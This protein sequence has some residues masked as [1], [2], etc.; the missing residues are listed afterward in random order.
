M[1]RK[2]LLL[3][4]VLALAG[5]AGTTMADTSSAE[6][7]LLMHQPAL[8][9]E[10]LA[11]VYG[12]DIW[13][14]KRDGSYPRKLTSHPAE[15][16][17]PQ[18]SPDGRWI[19]FSANYDNNTDVYVISTEGGTAKRLTWHPYSD[20]VNGWSVDGKRVLFASKREIENSRSNQLYEVAVDGG[21]PEKVMQ[22]VATEGSWSSDGKRL[23]Y[24]PYW[25]AFSGSSGW[26]LHRGGATPPIW[27]IDADGKNL[28]K[29]P[30]PNAS[31]TNPIW[32]GEDVFFLS[33]RDNKAVN[34]FRY[35]TATKQVEQ[36][37]HESVWD[38]KSANAYGDQIVYEV[39]G[40]LKTLNAKT[41][42]VSDLTLH[43]QPD[44][45]QLLPGW[46]NASNNLQAMA[47][48]PTG[49]RA[50]VTARG[51]VFTVPLDKGSTRNIT[52]T[53]GER[54]MNALWSPKGG[55]IA[56]VSDRGQKHALVIT[57]QDGANPKRFPLGDA[58]YTLLAWGAK[59]E[60]LIYQD[61]HL[62]LF[63]L[64]IK[65][66]KSTRIDTQSR[67]NDYNISISPDGRWMAYTFAG[68]NYFEHVVLYDFTSGEKFI[69]TDDMA[70]S[71]F[72]AF[73][74]DGKY[75]Y[76]VSSTNAGPLQNGLD[77]TTQEKPVRSGIYVAVLSADGVSPTLPEA[78]DETPVPDKKKK[79]DKKDKN[80]DEEVVTRVDLQGLRERIVA[81][82]VAEKFYTTLDVGEDGALYY[83]DHPQPG[84]SIEPPNSDHIGAT[85]LRYNFT[86]KEVQ[87][88][89]ENVDGFVLSKEGKHILVRSNHTMLSSA[90]VGE[91]LELEPLDLSNVKAWID[92]REEWR[93]IFE[94][95]WKMEKDY[96]YAENM[97]NIDWEAVRTRYTALL[98]HVITRE[99]LNRV[100]VNMIA[101]LQVGHNRVGGGDVHRESSVSVGLLGA[102]LRVENGHYRITK[103]FTGE[104]WNP[105]LKAPLSMP[106]IKVKE[107][108]YILAIN[109]RT[110]NP[111]A[112]I[113]AQ[114]V[115]TAG[116]QVTL[117]VN[118]SPQQKGAHDV[119]VTPI[120]NEVALRQWAWIEENRREVEAKTNGRVGYVY[121]PDTADGGYAYFNR[122]FFAQ[123]NK[124]ALIIDERKNNGGQAANYITDV[125]NRRYLASWKDRD[126]MLW[127]TP[128][129]GMYGPKVMLIDQ[130]AGSGGDFL[131]YS[132]KYMELGPT[133]GKRTW[134]G[135][136]GIS[137]NPGLIDGGYLVVPFFRFFTPE[138]KWA[139]E[140]EG[141]APDID[142]DLDP[143]AVNQGEDTQLQRAID[144]ALERLKTYTPIKQKRAPALPTKLGG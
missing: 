119:V 37:T 14:A 46:K 43:L 7:T 134:G 64:D 72:P 34:L 21:L 129:A 123:I 105:H 79:K 12:G 121:L 38:I 93:Q 9:A 99:D 4:C 100:L 144:E 102:N 80:K 120:S 61:N 11:F 97:H 135:L 25:A 71:S 118:S 28:E 130:D 47:L 18:F 94:D 122:M 2:N 67:R 109:G 39:G 142:V 57:E 49:K 75:L 137:A 13:L 35:S 24:S 85:L 90:E 77:M 48:S 128:A 140:N 5:N 131:P 132:F 8:S 59:D 55:K 133:I 106:G 78:G 20:V 81:L 6:Q 96:F 136:I 98:P 143:V 126:G 70:S 42:A 40:R 30:H 82:P 110:L 53:G 104:S 115:G 62:N 33:D 76:F 56:F 114:L 113:Y 92:P 29:V 26:R 19:A 124:E 52:N 91:S 32:V 101:E 111:E 89:Q 127:N 36:L 68:A 3:G 74:R 15:E 45:P 84:A 1:L 107:G 117:S 88:V 23:A 63:S 60:R 103:I 66:G 69:L 73:S 65:T 95:T 50:L 83:L 116:Q 51:E 112:N 86:E 125:L 17:H 87:S 138:G 139:V 58:Y 31:E 141:V 44:A 54:E 27:I 16:S 41:N 10:H 22:A 108:D